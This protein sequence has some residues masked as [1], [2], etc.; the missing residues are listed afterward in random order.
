M[1]EKGF[2]AAHQEK[3]KEKRNGANRGKASDL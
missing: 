3:L 2:S 1:S